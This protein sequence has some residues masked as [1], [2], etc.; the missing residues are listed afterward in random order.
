MKHR[1]EIVRREDLRPDD[2]PV[3]GRGAMIYGVVAA[4]VGFCLFLYLLFRIVVG[5]A[6]ADQ[7]EGI[8]HARIGTVAAAETTFVPIEAR[9]SAGGFRFVKGSIEHDPGLTVLDVLPGRDLTPDWTGL[10]NPSP[11][12]TQ[13]PN[14][15]GETGGI[16]L[17]YGLT[18]LAAPDWIEV[19]RLRVVGEGNIW[20]DCWCGAG[21]AHH[22][23]I[24][25]EGDVA[26]AWGYNA[27]DSHLVLENGAVTRT[28]A[29]LPLGWG[30]V[31]ALYR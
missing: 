18:P 25:Y 19:A 20:W 8:I 22:E 31:R 17:F 7:P 13:F 1:L 23:F 15:G 28:V 6:H 14:C 9:T 26:V 30:E 4:V 24:A 3:V 11:S 5:I 29:T 27:C 12:S 16:W 10:W 21:V 2:P